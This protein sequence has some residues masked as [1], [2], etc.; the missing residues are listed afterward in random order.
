MLDELNWWDSCDYL[1]E[2]LP[3]TG[4]EGRKYDEEMGL[5]TEQERGD[6]GGFVVEE[7]WEKAVR[8]AV[9]GLWVLPVQ[10]VDDEEEEVE[11]QDVGM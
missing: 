4:G 1:F 9:A 7:V 10:Q 6:E 2:I 3:R 8:T 11:G 5:G